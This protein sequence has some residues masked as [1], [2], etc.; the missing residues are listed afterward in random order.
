MWFIP[1]FLIGWATFPGVI[2]HEFAHKKACEWRKMPV[3]D[4][5]YFS[6]SGGGYVTHASPRQFSDTLAIS[7]AP[8]AVNTAIAYVLYTVAFILLEN[9]GA[10]SGGKPSNST[11]YA[12][13]AIG[14]L[15]LST[16]WHAI[17][18]FSDSGN[19][20]QGVTTNWRSSNLALF[21]IPVVIL[22]YIGNLLAFFWFDALYSL[23]IGAL[24]YA[25]VM[26][27]V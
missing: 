25:L 24:A 21:S 2:I 7:A 1:G 26:Y 13:V 3:R 8:F 5:D 20:W 17:P 6:L 10:L 18:S 22:F 14:W 23:G 9:A 12:G 11:A 4:V 16:G 19:I 15:A 27:G